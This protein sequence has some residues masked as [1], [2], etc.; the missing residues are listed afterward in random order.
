MLTS[1]IDDSLAQSR[2][3][4]PERASANE[5]RRT[6]KN[7]K[8]EKIYNNMKT[9]FDFF[10]I[11]FVYRLLFNYFTFQKQVIRR[12]NTKTV[13]ENQDRENTIS[14]EMAET[15]IYFT[16]PDVDEF[17][18]GAASIFERSE[19]EDL[20]FDHDSFHHYQNI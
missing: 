11:F 1:T 10:E 20:I 12:K 13:A 16:N 19:E 4:S 3:A 14:Q 5:M 17:G 7:K 9:T 18:P 6:R 2:E 15:G 8:V